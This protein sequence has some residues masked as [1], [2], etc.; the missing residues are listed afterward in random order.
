MNIVETYE[1]G[2]AARAMADLHRVLRTCRSYQASGA[3]ISLRAVPTTN[4][5]DETVTVHGQLR[6]P[7]KPPS[8]AYFVIVRCGD[9]V[10]TLEIPSLDDTDPAAHDLG[11]R[12][13]ARIRNRRGRPPR[14]TARSHLPAGSPTSWADILA[15]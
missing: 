11:R 5:C 14:P 15:S 9:Q 6:R 13:A 2:W 8:T 3:D 12:L 1:P 4:V 10:T 7:G